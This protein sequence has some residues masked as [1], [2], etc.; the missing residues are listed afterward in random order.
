MMPARFGVLNA[1]AAMECMKE[2]KVYERR[3]QRSHNSFVITVP[4]QIVRHLKAKAGRNI[5]FHTMPGKA[6]LTYANKELT[7]KDIRDID[8]FDE[9]PD[10]TTDPDVEMDKYERALDRMMGSAKAGSGKHRG[11]SALEKLRIK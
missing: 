8:R 7:K 4:A 6:V 1:P 9:A 2:G 10:G 5:A 3:L 11:A